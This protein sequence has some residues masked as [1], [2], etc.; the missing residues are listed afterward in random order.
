MRLPASSR[1]IRA[2]ALSM[3]AAGALALPATA[4]ATGV[5]VVDQRHGATPQGLAETLV[6]G[7]VSVS[8][9]VLTGPL[10]E[11]NIGRSAGT[12]TEGGSSIGFE[13]GIVMSTG[14]VQTYP[15][16]PACSQGVEGPNT[17][18]EATGAKPSGPSGWTN[19][20][21]LEAPGDEALTTLS[22]FPTFDA[23]VLEFDFVPQHGSIQ[24]SYVFGS[25]EYSDFSNTPYNDVFAF[26]INGN[27]C[28]LVP[29][30]TEPVAVNTINNGND[31]EGGDPTPHHP[32]LFRDNVRPAPSIQSQLDG[33]TSMLTCTATVTP[34]V[35]NHMRLAIADAS[36]PIYD[37]AVFI[38]SKSLISGTQVSTQL[39]GGTQ[40]GEKITVAQGTAV[41]DHAILS[42][43]EAPGA[44]GSV[45]YNV[46]SDH[47]CK[48]LVGAA[49]TVGVAGGTA[50]PSTPQTLPIG[51]YYWQASYS[52]DAKNNAAKSECGAE[53]LTV[54][55]S[56]EEEPPGEA[57]PTTTLTSLSGGGQTGASINVGEGTSVV[58]QAT[59]RGSNAVEATG[60]LSYA[61]YSDAACTQLAAGAGTVSVSGGVA[62]PSNALT[63]PTG[64]YYWQAAYSGDAGNLPSKS[65]C[66]TEI[67]N[68]GT[69][70][71]HQEAPEFGRCVKVAKG[72]G[73]YAGTTCT[74]LG[75]AD[76]YEWISGTAKSHYTLALKEGTVTLET[77]NGHK[78]ICTGATGH[79]DYTGAHTV[80]NTVL[81]LTGCELSKVP[82][83]SAGAAEGEVVSDVLAGKLGVI[84]A[85]TTPYKD[86]IGL[87]LSSAGGGTH[88]ANFSCRGASV[89]VVGSVIVPVPAT[90]KMLVTSALTYTAGTKGRQKPEAFAGEPKD[91]LETSLGGVPFEQ[92]GLKAKLIE[93]SEEPVEVNSVV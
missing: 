54:A 25:D 37:S 76:T 92:T 15:E 78:I 42:G 32:E 23:T 35:A 91:V 79:G 2:A 74:S 4:A 45:E 21:N 75:G 39:T 36:D 38:Q 27:N 88:V 20:T 7:G 11:A 71:P 28:A 66:G 16:D 64:T 53:V 34:G 90:N 70:G 77:S 65:A 43:P 44:T 85:G 17:C 30:T 81:V 6:G 82:C 62:G 58:D 8:N 63:L 68:V 57:D 67:L 10:G 59:I 93:T 12:F 51:T 14:R 73:K 56:E 87:D 1:G 40:S 86:K 3:T 48:T 9:V 46:Y 80:G 31:Q 19:A 83:Q 47:E 22:G 49:G 60:T 29:G 84:T 33:L 55:A 72:S 26:W 5:S 41:S 50:P 69:S 61:A 24:F 13:S 89:V 52:G 18:Y